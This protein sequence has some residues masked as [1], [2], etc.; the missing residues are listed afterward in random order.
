MGTEMTHRRSH[1]FDVEPIHQ[2][3]H[4][5]I[6][7]RQRL[8]RTSNTNLRGIFPQGDIAPPVKAILDAPMR[9]HEAKET[10]GIGGLPWQIGDPIDGLLSFVVALFD[11]AAYAKDLGDP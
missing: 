8:G 5:A 11:R 3:Q 1:I 6:E 9:L 10:S 7:G 2:S 4:P